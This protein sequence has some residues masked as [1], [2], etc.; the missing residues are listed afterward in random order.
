MYKNYF[1]SSM[2][3]LIK[4]G[5]IQMFCPFWSLVLFR[6]HNWIE[7]AK[8]IHWKNKTDR[9]FDLK[10][11]VFE[12]CRADGVKNKNS[13]H[14]ASSQLW[15]VWEFKVFRNYFYF[16]QNIFLSNS[17]TGCYSNYIGR[18]INLLYILS[19]IFVYSRLKLIIQFEYFE[20]WQKWK[21]L[22]ASFP[23]GLSIWHN[24]PTSGN[25]V[26]AQV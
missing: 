18:S 9:C 2:L 3:F 26:N 19:K 12:A 13:R 1:N 23:N 17:P 21:V 5:N 6:I 16:L 11:L 20:L 8:G 15:D 25:Y 24:F 7:M 4:T 14:F 10:K 22:D